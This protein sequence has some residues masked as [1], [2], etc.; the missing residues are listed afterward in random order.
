MQSCTREACAR[1]LYHA[2]A[3][4]LNGVL[5][6]P[7]GPSGYKPGWAPSSKL[8]AP[9]P[10]TSQLAE[11]PAHR[12][13]RGQGAAG[14]ADAAA[15]SSY[16]AGAGG[17]W[18]LSAPAGVGKR[19]Q[20]PQP[21]KLDSFPELAA[22]EQ[23]FQ[24]RQQQ[25]DQAQANSPAKQFDVQLLGSSG[26]LLPSGLNASISDPRSLVPVRIGVADGDCVG[27]SPDAGPVAVALAAADSQVRPI[28]V[29]LPADLTA[30]A[31]AAAADGAGD[32]AAGQNVN[33]D[34]P[35]Q[36]DP[37]ALTW[38]QRN[39]WF[40]TDEEMTRLAYEVRTVQQFPRRAHSGTLFCAYI[41]HDFAWLT[42]SQDPHGNN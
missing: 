10:R 42:D 40:G 35:A 37:K 28:A 6:A 12:P 2:G 23:Q 9:P 31:A 32:G 39:V 33:A 18:G 29:P 26:V 3:S 34:G 25:Q 41:H 4:G 27:T 36:P 21:P 19:A 15:S 5:A 38:A 30:S 7:Q 17:I 16:Q 8:D 14:G 11:L 24:M 20:E 1:D 13:G 22:L